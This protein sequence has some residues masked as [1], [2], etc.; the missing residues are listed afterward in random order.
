MSLRKLSYRFNG[1]GMTNITNL[2]RSAATVYYFLKGQVPVRIM[3]VLVMIIHGVESL[4][5]GMIGVM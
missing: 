2:L 3:T 1:G 5:F 4:H